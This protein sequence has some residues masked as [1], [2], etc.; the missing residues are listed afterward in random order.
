ML[1]LVIFLILLVPAT[2]CT[3]FLIFTIHLLDLPHFPLW[4]NVT[5][6]LGLLSWFLGD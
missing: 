6:A 2:W 5:I 3:D 4:F 1:V